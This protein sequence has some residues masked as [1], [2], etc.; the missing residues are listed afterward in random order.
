MACTAATT[1][2]ALVKLYAHTHH[3]THSPYDDI[4]CKHHH[5]NCA[6]YGLTNCL[7]SSLIV[8][9]I[10]IIQTRYAQPLR[11]RHYL[12]MYVCMRVCLYVCMYVRMHVHM[13][14]C[15]YLCVCVHGQ[16]SVRRHRLR[17]RLQH[18][19]VQ[20]LVKGFDYL[21]YTQASHTHP[22]ARSLKMCRDIFTSLT[23]PL[24]HP[25][26]HPPTQS[27]IESLTQ[28]PSHAR[29]FSLSLLYARTHTYTPPLTCHSTENGTWACECAEGYNGGGVEK[30]CERGY[31]K[32]TGNQGF[33]KADDITYQ[34]D[35]LV[36][37][38]EYSA[39]YGNHCGKHDEHSHDENGSIA[40]QQWKNQSW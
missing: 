30:I 7:G 9:H 22:L 8:M 36:K 23:N 34:G 39:D 17:R 1:N 2:C 21:L 40:E 31:C 16:R 10:P 27:L 25:P 14:V 20:I 28:S 18:M 35:I 15:V 4:C 32:C 13:Y 6:G 11:S 5:P 38:Y 29:T 37:G 24:T 3:D 33:Y 12:C 19:Q 26:T